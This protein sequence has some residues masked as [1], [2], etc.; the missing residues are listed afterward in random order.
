MTCNEDVPWGSN[1]YKSVTLGDGLALM[2]RYAITRT[3]DTHNLRL[4]M[5]LSFPWRSNDKESSHYFFQV[6]AWIQAISWF[7][8]I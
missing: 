1:D 8:K 5:Q 3:V 2:K 4:H 7:T 6:M